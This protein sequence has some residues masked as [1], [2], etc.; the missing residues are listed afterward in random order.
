M[1]S[2][3]RRVVH[4]LLFIRLHD[5]HRLENLILSILLVIVIQIDVKHLISI[6][7]LSNYVQVIT[8]ADECMS[9]LQKILWKFYS[10]NAAWLKCIQEP[11]VVFV[12]LNT[13]ERDIWPVNTDASILLEHLRVDIVLSILPFA[14]IF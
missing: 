12:T 3:Q 13:L 7:P 10:I 11:N 5:C 2:N 9:D 1:K 6:F 14:L 4:Q 8:F